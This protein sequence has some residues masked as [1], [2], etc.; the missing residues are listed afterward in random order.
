VLSSASKGY[1]ALGGVEIK[2]RLSSAKIGYGRRRTTGEMISVTK[3]Q[4]D[5]MSARKE[6]K[7][8]SNKR[9]ASSGG[10]SNRSRSILGQSL[11]R[12]RT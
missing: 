10:G 3:G 8:Y 12:E 1:K 7:E 4:K 11:S 5:I 2:K 9:N 6:L